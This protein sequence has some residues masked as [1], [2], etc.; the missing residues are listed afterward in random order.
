MNWQLE[1]IAAKLTEGS[2]AGSC[3]LGTDGSRLL[4]ERRPPFSV[5]AIGPAPRT[6]LARPSE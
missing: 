3:L 4:T 2:V 5:T 6:Q 1:V